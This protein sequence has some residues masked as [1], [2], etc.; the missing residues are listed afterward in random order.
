MLQVILNVS[1]EQSYFFIKQLIYAMVSLLQEAFVM[2]Q[3]SILSTLDRMFS[4]YD[5][6]LYESRALKL[7][8]F[9]GTLAVFIHVLTSAKQTNNARGILYAGELQRA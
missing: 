6:I 7:F 3:G 4:L 8:V 1:E 5:N 9:Y 2:K